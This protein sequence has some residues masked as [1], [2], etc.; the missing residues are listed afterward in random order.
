M[1]KLTALLLSVVLVLSLAAAAL[2]TSLHL[3]PRSPKPL[4]RPNSRHG[5]VRKLL[6][7]SRR[8][9]AG[10]PARDRQD[11]GGLLLRFR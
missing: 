5:T 11:T 10:D 1:K 8:I 7:R 9:R 6:D 4:R 3:P 2:S